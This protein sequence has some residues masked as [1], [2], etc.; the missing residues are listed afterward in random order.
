[1]KPHYLL[2]SLCVLLFLSCSSSSSKKP[3]EIVRGTLDLTS[4][5]LDRDGPLELFGEA[6]FFWSI[7]LTPEDFGD[8]PEPQKTGYIQ[9]PGAWNGYAIG[10]TELGS[11]G[12][13][14][15][16]IRVKLRKVYAEPLGLRF[17]NE[18]GAFR[19]YIDDRTLIQAGTV[20]PTKEWT[21]PD[22]S[23]RIAPFRPSQ[24]EFDILVQVSNFH[25]FMGGMVCNIH[26]G[27][28]QGISRKR[29]HGL[30]VDLFLLGAFFIMGCYHLGLFAMWRSNKAALY[31]ALLC[32]IGSGYCLI[33]GEKYLFYAF[34]DIPWNVSFRL[35]YFLTYCIMIAVLTFCHYL[36]EEESSIKIVRIFQ[37]VYTALVATTLFFN[38]YIYTGCLL[39]YYGAVILG[40]AY[41]Y[42]LGIRAIINKRSG[43]IVYI[44]GFSM[45]FLSTL[46]DMLFTL[47]IIHTGDYMPYAL[48]CFFISQAYMLA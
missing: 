37:G 32:F 43:A 20:G 14:T 4:W 41:I 29:S 5:D 19:V 25:S 44:G 27:T 42:Y 46:N 7:L 18:I 3:P 6:A 10:A 15:Y 36:F 21:V 33:V 23:T 24:E 1:M 39:I 47:K 45:M 40:F 34:S 17:S 35:I 13:A 22:Y 38:S 30:A 28:E 31:F 12:T 48:V 9:M 16:R 2:F 8:G 11:Y 26:L